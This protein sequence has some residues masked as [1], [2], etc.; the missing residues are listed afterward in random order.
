MS[1]TELPSGRE[2]VEPEERDDYTMV[3]YAERFAVWAHGGQLYGDRPYKAHLREVVAILDDHAYDLHYHPL[4]VIGGWL[5][6]VVEDTPVTVD[7]IADRF[8]DAVANIVW[9]CTGVGMN[10]KARQASIHAKLLEE[11]DAQPVKAADRLANMRSALVEQKTGLVKMY[12][13]EFDQFITGVPLAAP[14]LLSALRETQRHCVEFLT[15]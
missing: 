11:P 10:R 13:D 7:M 8:G 4:V 1:P 12:A 6:D 14:S 2:P 5:H 15:R 3:P 9:A